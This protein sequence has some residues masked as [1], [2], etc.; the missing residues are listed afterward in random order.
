[1]WHKVITLVI[2]CDVS[3]WLYSSDQ[4]VHHHQS[5]S[6]HSSIWKKPVTV[7]IMCLERRSSTKWY[8]YEYCVSMIHSLLVVTYSPSFT[9]NYAEACTLYSNSQKCCHVS[10]NLFRM[11]NVCA[12]TS[13]R[14]TKWR[15]YRLCPFVLCTIVLEDL[16][17]R[18][19]LLTTRY[20]RK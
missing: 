1:M 19:M 17:H 11:H 4:V 12:R 10:F 2:F 14:K 3:V 8:S 13:R 7:T 15:D 5:R 9:L 20:C 18:Q 6:I 16:Q